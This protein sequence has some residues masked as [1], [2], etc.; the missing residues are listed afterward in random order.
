[1]NLA[2]AGHVPTPTEYKGV[3]FRSKS[4]AVF[5]RAIDIVNEWWDGRPKAPGT[6]LRPTRFSWMYEP[7]AHSHDWDFEIVD[8]HCQYCGAR[9]L[10]IEY[11]P[12]MPTMTYV[13][14]LIAK[15]RESAERYQGRTPIDSYIVWGSPWN[16]PQTGW[17]TVYVCY[18][19]FSRWGKFGWGDFE[20]MADHGANEPWSYRHDLTQI[21]GIDD[22]IAREATQ[23]RFDLAEVV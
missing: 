11:K 1:M 17:G 16:P 2:N 10:L 12:S 14:N 23:Y 7:K 15:V 21:L 6:V 20:P 9:I 4:E 19:V 8:R 18:P 13:N 22:E 3:V 5:A